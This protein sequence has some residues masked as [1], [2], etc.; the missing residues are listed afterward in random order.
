TVA[1][2][3][4]TGRADTAEEFWDQQYEASIALREMLE[5]LPEDVRAEIRADAVRTIGAMFPQGPV[6][7]Q[8]EALVGVGINP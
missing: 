7:F 2:Q 1:V 6:E 3:V 4:V 8:G 5:P